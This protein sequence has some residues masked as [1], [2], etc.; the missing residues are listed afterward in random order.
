MNEYLGTDINVSPISEYYESESSTIHKVS[1]DF[2]YGDDNCNE[3]RVAELIFY[4]I[5][6]K[7]FADKESIYYDLDA[8]DSDTE[9]YGSYIRD[10]IKKNYTCY[11]AIQRLYVNPKCRRNY[12]GKYIVSK[13]ESII[14][15]INPLLS[16]DSIRIIGFIEPDK[17]EF[18]TDNMKE[19]MV[20]LLKDRHYKIKEH[21]GTTMIDRECRVY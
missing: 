19:V 20:H 7:D 8:I 10:R 11:V 21:N 16:G 12:I 18:C 17:D 9:I 3:E 15:E 2:I 5:Y 14:T 4:M 6:P 1:C 13:L